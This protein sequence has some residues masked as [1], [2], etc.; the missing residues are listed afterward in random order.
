M[1][2]LKGVRVGYV[3]VPQS[4]Q[5]VGE[6]Q[7]AP[8]TIQS[9]V[10]EVVVA[11]EEVWGVVAEAELEDGEAATEAIETEPTSEVVAA[12]AAAAAAEEGGV[13]EVADVS[14]LFDV[15]EV[16]AL[17]AEI[18][19]S[20]S[21]AD[22][23]RLVED[24]VEVPLDAGTND[25]AVSIEAEIAESVTILVEA[26]LDIEAEACGLLE[27]GIDVPVEGKDAVFSLVSADSEFVVSVVVLRVLLVGVSDPEAMLRNVDCVPGADII[28]A[29]EPLAVEA[30]PAAV[31]PGPELGP[32]VIDPEKV[33]PDEELGA[34]AAPRVVESVPGASEKEYEV[35]G[36]AELDELVES[37][38]DA[39]DVTVP[40]L[41]ID[42]N[43][44]FDVALIPL[45]GES[46]VESVPGGRE[47]EYEVSGHAEALEL[48]EPNDDP[49]DEAPLEDAID[50]TV[51]VLI[52]VLLAGVSVVESVPGGNENVYEVSAHAEFEV[53]LLLEVD[54][55]VLLLDVDDWALD[56]AVDEEEGVPKACVSVL[57]PVSLAYVPLGSY[58]TENYFRRDSILAD[59]QGGCSVGY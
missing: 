33:P 17:V 43:A 48:V 52:S 18:V 56:D 59:Y 53:A 27:S 23:M 15:N 50:G 44:R 36:Q 7:G 29:G 39:V 8:S 46:F 51:S 28:E 41:D 47:N 21:G 40:L 5:L 54:E 12:A 16:V 31:S 6:Y 49:V 35:R 58:L 11:R 3:S 9:G 25:E 57:F 24:T 2:P 19:D 34:E 45:A 22:K 4:H 13:E 30:E 42:D 55:A 10:G 37:A 1:A 38:D 32:S 14:K 26:P 20:K